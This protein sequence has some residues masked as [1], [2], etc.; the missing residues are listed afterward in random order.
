MFLKRGLLH[1]KTPKKEG[2]STKKKSQLNLYVY[3]V[4]WPFGILHNCPLFSDLFKPRTKWKQMWFS[5]QKQTT[6]PNNCIK[7]LG[8]PL[9]KDMNMCSN[10]KYVDHRQRRP[11][12]QRYNSFSA[13]T[14]THLT[15]ITSTTKT[16]LHNYLKILSSKYLW[17]LSI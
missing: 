14:D 13:M 2:I 10:N 3:F 1:S 4:D 15:K 12:R 6:Y 16:S 9:Y 11:C 7:R 5:I 8:Y 17:P